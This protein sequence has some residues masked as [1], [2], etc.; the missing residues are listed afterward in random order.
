MTNTPESTTPNPEPTAAAAI[1]VKNDKTNRL[2]AILAGSAV[3]LFLL[4]ILTG[5]GVTAV[6]SGL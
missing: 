1:A 3:L 4:G 6:S 2:T 5:V